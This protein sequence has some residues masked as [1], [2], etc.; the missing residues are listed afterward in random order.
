MTKT[1]KTT[2]KVHVPLHRRI[3]LPISLLFIVLLV[4]VLLVTSII[5]TMTNR[6]RYN[7]IVAVYNSID[8][9]S[10]YL[11]QR[12]EVFGDKRVYEYDAGR[13]TSSARYYTRGANVDV[14]ARE[15]DEKIKAAGFEFFD[16]PYAGSLQKQYHYKK[17]GVYVR[18]SVDSKLRSDAFFNTFWMKGNMDALNTIDPNAGPSDVIIKVN[19]DDNNE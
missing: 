7:K 2:K 8:V 12:D 19:L 16:E 6:A 14:T 3:I 15:L 9:G 10:E 13:T 11:L 5:P 17:D 4:A 18:L 1:K